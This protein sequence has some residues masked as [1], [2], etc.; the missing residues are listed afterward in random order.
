VAAD[1]AGPLGVEAVGLAAAAGRV[2]ATP[3]RAAVSLPGFD[4]ARS[5]GADG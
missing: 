5:H 4:A 3:V 2:L 1:S